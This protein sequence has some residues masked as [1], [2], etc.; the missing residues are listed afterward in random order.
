MLNRWFMFAMWNLSAWFAGCGSCPPET[1]Q[2][3]GSVAVRCVKARSDL[4]IWLGDYVE[5]REDCAPQGNVCLAAPEPMCVA[6]GAARCAR[7]D[8]ERCSADERHV[9]YCNDM[10][11]WTHAR[12]PCEHGCRAV[13][14]IAACAPS[15]IES[16]RPHS[17]SRLQ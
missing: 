8:A 11:Y 16:T 2:C 3:L 7:G 1:G 12:E 15:P 13:D 5:K 6:P 14:G 4:G 10:G 9:I 17:G